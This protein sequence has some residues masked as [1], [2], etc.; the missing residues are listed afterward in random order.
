MNAFELLRAYV[1]ARQ[2]AVLLGLALL[3]WPAALILRSVDSS[4]DAPVAV[5][6][7]AAAALG[8]GSL[9]WI[10]RRAPLRTLAPGLVCAAIA[11]AFVWVVIDGS[12]ALA[13]G[14]SAL[15]GAAV[16][17]ALVAAVRAAVRRLAPRRPGPFG[18]DGAPGR[19]TPFGAD[20]GSL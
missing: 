16:T 7:A 18:A 10:V 9:L 8:I 11:A 19:Q 17:W 1:L 5:V 4:A 12:I 20:G 6:A 13:W 14:W 15:F 3:A 2:A